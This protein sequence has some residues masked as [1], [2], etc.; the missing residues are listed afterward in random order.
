MQ[1]FEYIY[2]YTHIYMYIHIHIVAMVCVVERIY[3]YIYMYTHT[4]IYLYIC[5]SL[6]TYICIYIYIYMHTYSCRR[7]YVCVVERM[8]DAIPGIYSPKSARSPIYQRTY[9]QSYFF[10]ENLYYWALTSLPLSPQ[11]FSKVIL[12]L[13]LLQKM[14][15]ELTFEKFQ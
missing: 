8:G 4:Y 6:S 10:L 7:Y 13:N 2:M 5:K 1:H 9:L 14:T 3:A 12:L 15:S 11:K